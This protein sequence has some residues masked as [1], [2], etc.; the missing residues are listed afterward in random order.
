MRRLKVSLVAVFALAGLVALIPGG[1]MAA[2]HATVTI[3]QVGA[4]SLNSHN[5]L[6]SFTVNTPPL[7]PAS[8]AGKTVTVNVNSNTKFMPMSGTTTSNP[9]A[10]N[11]FVWASGG[12][13][14]HQYASTVK[15]DTAPF[16]VPYAKR[17]FNGKFVSIVAIVPPADGSLV[18]KNSAGKDLTFNTNAKTAYRLNGKRQKTQP[19]YTLGERMTVYGQEYTDGSWLAQRIDA[20]KK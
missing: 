8:P 3:G 11:D 5:Q 4:L 2:S 12:V 6:V 10:A 16:A 1:A 7:A 18:I 9:F 17:T 13:G 19:A 14:K 15:Y 20:F